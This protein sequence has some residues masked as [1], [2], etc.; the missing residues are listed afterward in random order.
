MFDFEDNDAERVIDAE[1]V[2]TRWP[3]EELGT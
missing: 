2:M 3:V 1:L